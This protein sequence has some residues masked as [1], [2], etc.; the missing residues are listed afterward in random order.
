[1]PTTS[2]ALGPQW[3]SYSADWLMDR[4]DARP[5]DE[6]FEYVTDSGAIDLRPH[7]RVAS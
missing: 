1:L 4:I 5:A 2:V 7:P 3:V 6:R